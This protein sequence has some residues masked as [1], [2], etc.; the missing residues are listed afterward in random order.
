[1]I[2]AEASHVWFVLHAEASRSAACV[3]GQVCNQRAG[4]PCAL[5]STCTIAVGCHTAFGIAGCCC[6]LHTRLAHTSVVYGLAGMEYAAEL[7]ELS[8]A[9]VAGRP[10]GSLSMLRSWSSSCRTLFAA[11]L[12]AYTSS[13]VCCLW[14]AAACPKELSAVWGLKHGA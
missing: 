3:L 2:A 8:T 9:A 13:R 4:Y 11:M 12:P 14:A 1:V 7:G 6:C 10:K 5:Y